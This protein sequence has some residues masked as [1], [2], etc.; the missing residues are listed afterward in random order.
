[1]NGIKFHPHF[2]KEW[3]QNVVEQFHSFV[4]NYFVLITWFI[5]KSHLLLIR[6]YI[7]PYDLYITHHIPWCETTIPSSPLNCLTLYLIP[8]KVEYT[9]SSQI[10]S[11]LHQIHSSYYHPLKNKSKLVNILEMLRIVFAL[12]NF[13]FGTTLMWV[14]YICPNRRL[15]TPFAPYKHNLAFCRP[16]SMASLLSML[17]VNTA[18]L[19]DFFTLV[20]VS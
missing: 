3:R 11:S 9:S 4:T 10:K 12:T 2:R 19:R 18:H 17:S 7:Y 8:T 15:N 1:M 13:L 20:S 5:S 16:H 14:G 6:R